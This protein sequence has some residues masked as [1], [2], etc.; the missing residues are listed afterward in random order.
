MNS[1]SFVI[2]ASAL[3][4]FLINGES[5]GPAD[6]GGRL[7]APTMLPYEVTNI[8]RRTALRENIAP[9]AQREAFDDLHGMAIEM[10]PWPAVSER[11]WELRHNLTAYDASYV[12]VSELADAVLIT[13][14]RKLAAAPGI[15]CAVEVLP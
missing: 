3:V 12:A 1:P 6:A 8:I 10:W 7:L 13:K 15:R 11:V 5:L 14:D 4:P 9:A 2:D